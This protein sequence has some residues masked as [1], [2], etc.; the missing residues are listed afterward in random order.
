[1]YLTISVSSNYYFFKSESATRRLNKLNFVERC[2]INGF[3]LKIFRS[4]RSGK[5][6]CGKLNSL[7]PQSMFFNHEAKRKCVIVYLFSLLDNTDKSLVG[8]QCTS[9]SNVEPRRHPCLHVLILRAISS[10]SWEARDFAKRV[11]HKTFIKLAC[12]DADEDKVL[13]C[14]KTHTV[15]SCFRTNPPNW[16]RER[17]RET[18]R[19]RE[20]ATCF[21][22]DS[23]TMIY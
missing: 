14:G 3:P 21:L 13:L 1:M 9:C 2:I 15:R 6:A 11:N 19:E 17:D 8:R 4:Y 10:L 23:L 18:E 7:S 20:I 16:D 5:T 22:L 12:R